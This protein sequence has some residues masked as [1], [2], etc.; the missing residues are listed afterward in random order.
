[1]SILAQHQSR[2]RWLFVV[3]FCMA[4]A[5]MPLQAAQRPHV[6]MISIDGMRPDYVTAGD[7]HHLHIPTL[8]AFLKDGTYAEGVKGVV[9]TLT[10]PSHTTLV[11]G[12]SPSV[13]GIYANAKFDPTQNHKN[14]SY[15]YTNDIKVQTLWEAASAAGLST[16]NVGWPVTVGA[17]GLEESLPAV[18]PYER[19]SA[20]DEPNFLHQSYDHPSGLRK[21]ADA[22]LPRVMP[23]GYEKRFYWG[24]YVMQRYKPDFMLVHLALLDHTEHMT[25]P[26]SERSDRVLEAIDS[27]V[28]QLI[29]AEH[30]IDPDSI[31]V[32]VSDHG[33]S[34]LHKRVNL[35]VL[36]AQDRLIDLAPR[37][38]AHHR[39]EVSSWKAQLWPTGGTT[40]VLLHDPSDAVA[41]AKVK[42]LLEKA[43]SNPEYGIEKILSRDEAIQRGGFADPRM[44]FVVAWKLGYS[45]GG[46]LTGPVIVPVARGGAHGYLP[47]HPE[48][49]SSFFMEGKGVAKGRNLGEIDMRQIAP[50]VAEILGVHLPQAKLPPVHYQP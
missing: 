20:D 41:R 13:H 14:D 21:L 10:Y 8:R 9:P 48:L 2:L 39:V 34:P 4:F 40:A 27:E 37:T 29:Q 33:F 32:I 45:G 28:A 12:V 30:A 5:A 7:A 49:H 50:T 43:A 25:G 35:G 11:T 46:A 17:K 44:A 36:F 22:A 31:I 6:L 15:W 1:M 42:A 3:L 38:S 19:T 16:A 18:P 47:E 23:P 24:L 26:F